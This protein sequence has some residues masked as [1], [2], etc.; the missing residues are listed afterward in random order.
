VQHPQKL[1]SLMNFSLNNKLEK[2]LVTGIDVFKPIEYNN[3]KLHF[4]PACIY[5]YTIGVNTLIQKKKPK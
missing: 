4:I 2:A 3:L 5:A 1:G